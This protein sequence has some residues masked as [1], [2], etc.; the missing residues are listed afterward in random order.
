[1]AKIASLVKQ[2]D[3]TE[4][5]C[6][7]DDKN[8]SPFWFFCVNK[9]NLFSAFFIKNDHFW[10][11]APFFIKNHTLDTLDNIIKHQ[12]GLFSYCEHELDDDHEL[13]T[14]IGGNFLETVYFAL[15]PI[16]KKM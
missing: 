2:L 7:D 6:E 11:K 10:Q 12:K 3:Q 1:L 13:E 5:T 8:L 4:V 15:R 9:K 16:S 14:E